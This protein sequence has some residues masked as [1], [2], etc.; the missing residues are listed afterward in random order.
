MHEWE[1]VM[2]VLVENWHLIGITLGMMAFVSYL[3]QMYS[4]V[5]SLP[6]AIS[7]AEFTAFPLIHMED[8]SHNT[9]LFRF[10]LKHPGQ[11]LE[12]PI[13]KHISVMGYDENNEEVRRP[14]T[15]TT[16][17]DTRGH[18]DLVVKIYPQG[19][20]S[21][22]F[23]RL[24]IGKTLL[25]RGPMGRFKYQPNMKSFFGMVAGGT[26]I[27]PMFQVIKAI[28]ENPKDKTKL[29]LIFGNIT[30]DDILLKE[31][32][33]TFQKSHPDRLEIFYILDKPPRGWTGGKGYVTP[34]M[35]TE[36]FGSPSDSRMVLSCGPPP[37]KKSVKAHLE[38]LGFS[39]DM[40]F[41]F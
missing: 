23:N 25:F 10:G 3:M 17:A 31:E 2:E 33:D 19:K 5:R 28:L 14:Y 7:K 6:A 21:Q 37:M 35:I 16:L 1:N 12:L 32:L 34:Q 29:S 13:G 4:V 26:G 39:D 22:I 9:K 41:E 27:T 24:T 38:A 8:V 36:R 11:S 15:P 40:L 30:E 18:F 20:M